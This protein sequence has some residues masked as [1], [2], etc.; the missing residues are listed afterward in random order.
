[1]GHRRIKLVMGSQPLSSPTLLRSSAKLAEALL[2]QLSRRG[3]VLNAGDVMYSEFRWATAAATVRRWL[4][5]ADR[6]TCIL[7][8]S[9][10][11]AI[12]VMA[13]A[14]EL[15]LR[16]PQDLSVASYGD[17]RRDVSLTSVHVP[18]EE[19]GAA[20]M[21]RLDET[22]AHRAAEVTCLPVTIRV[23]RSTAH[24]PDVA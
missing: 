12:E 1:M 9:D 18:L 22:I 4:R 14:T 23:R 21:D 11:L 24:R 2:E 8:C 3:I 10:S 5:S 17:V 6:P 7:C 13:L 15:N 16:V 19:M 20:L